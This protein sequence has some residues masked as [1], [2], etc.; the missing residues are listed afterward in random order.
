MSPHPSKPLFGHVPCLL[1]HCVVCML[2]M[3]LSSC[4]PVTPWI[5]L[6]HYYIVVDNMIIMM[7]TIFDEGWEVRL[8]R[9]G[10]LFHS[11][12]PRIRVPGIGSLFERA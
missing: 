5:G 10:V 12:H 2:G 3:L 1:N 9:L 7:L 8:S 11:S 4:S 6:S